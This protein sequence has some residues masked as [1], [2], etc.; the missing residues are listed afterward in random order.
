MTDGKAASSAPRKRR[1]APKAQPA[2]AA[3]PTTPD[4]IEIAMDLAATGQAPSAAARAILERQA[5]L[6]GWQIASE[7]AGFA[8]KVLTGLA[9][10]AVA[11]TIGLI[12]FMLGFIADLQSVNRRLLEGIDWRL[13]QLEQG[14]PRHAREAT[15]ERE[16][17]A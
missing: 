4:A 1:T 6:I 13:R 11:V 17:A 8:L 15:G 7:R 9:G 2:T 3:D 14:S 16:R 5:Q 12:L 10:V